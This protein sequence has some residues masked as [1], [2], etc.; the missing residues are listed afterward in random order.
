MTID[1]LL[2]DKNDLVPLMAQ[3]SNNF[4]SDLLMLSPAGYIIVAFLIIGDCIH[5]R[6]IFSNNLHGGSRG[7]LNMF[8]QLSEIILAGQ[9]YGLLDL[10]HFNLTKHWLS[11]IQSE[12]MWWITRVHWIENILDIL[13]TV[14]AIQW[15]SRASG[16]LLYLPQGGWDVWWC[17]CVLIK[18][19]Y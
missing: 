3:F 14:L 1:K 19:S 18:T 16:F 13:D 12:A 8:Y 9:R 17:C 4:L 11:L 6:R 7:K 15:Q 2:N 5:Y 10:K